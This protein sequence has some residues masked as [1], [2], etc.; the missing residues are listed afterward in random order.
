MSLSKYKA[1]HVWKTTEIITLVE[2][3]KENNDKTT[4]AKLIKSKLQMPRA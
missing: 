4:S 1:N 2:A 3:K